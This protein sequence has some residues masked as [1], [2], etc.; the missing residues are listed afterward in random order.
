M[1]NYDMRNIIRVIHF[2][3]MLKLLVQLSLKHDTMLDDVVPVGTQWDPLLWVKSGLSYDHEHSLPFAAFYYECQNNHEIWVNV[4][5]CFAVM[6]KMCR[7]GVMWKL[8]S[9]KICGVG[10]PGYAVLH[11]ILQYT[12]WI[13]NY[14]QCNYN[15]GL[16]TA[17]LSLYWTNIRILIT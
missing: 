6:P 12:Y 17:A 15:Y 16:M 9:K 14:H 3:A 13:H 1:S 11:H 7:L 8:R 2:L 10:N 4:L 5:I